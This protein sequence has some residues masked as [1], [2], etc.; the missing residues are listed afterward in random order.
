M[1]LDLKQGLTWAPVTPSRS[2]RPL[3]LCARAGCGAP[4]KK[5]TARYCS[6]ACSAQDPERRARLRERA[7][8]GRI[9]PLARQL[10]LDFDGEEQGI[11]A[12]AGAREEV[13]QGLARWAV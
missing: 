7:R 12:L 8:G 6:V 10:P 2:P 1:T 3:R 11:A 5:P 13:P 9:L 4:V